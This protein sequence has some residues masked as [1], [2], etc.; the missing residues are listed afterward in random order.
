MCFKFQPTDQTNKKP[1]VPLIP[2]IVG[3]GAD[4]MN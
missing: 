3:D 2:P 4:K 1:T